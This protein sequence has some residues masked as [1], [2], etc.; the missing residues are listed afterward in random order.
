VP[1]VLSLVLAVCLGWSAVVVAASPPSETLFPSNTKGWV[2]FPNVDLLRSDFKLTQ[3][4]K[5][6]EDPAMQP[7]MEDLGEQLEEKLN[8]AGVK[9]GLKLADLDGV[10]GGEVAT[11]M[12]KP[13]PKDKNSHALAFVVDITGKAKAAHELLEKIDKNLIAKGAKK[14]SKKVGTTTVISYLLPK[15]A[16]EKAPVTAY[17]AIEGNTLIAADNESVVLGILTRLEGKAADSLGATPA[18]K[19]VAAKVHGKK[20]ALD[21]HIRWFVEPLGYA[22]AARAANGGKVKRG[23]DKIRIL[24]EQGFTCI[25]GIG[26]RLDFHHGDHE[27]LHQSFAYAPADPRAKKPL[28][29]V[30]AAN[31]LDFPNSP[32]LE[33]QDWVPNHVSSYLSFNWD[34]QKAFEHFGSIFDAFADDPGTWDEVIGGLETDPSGPEIN[35]KDELIK[36]LG[37]RVTA[38]VDYRLPIDP[39]CE[40]VLVAIELNGKIDGVEKKVQDAIRKLMK[41]E[42]DAR[43][44]KIEGHD[45]WEVSERTEEAEIPELNIDS[46]EFVA[47][48]GKAV[49]EKDGEAVAVAAPAVKEKKINWAITVAKGHVFIGTHVA[50]IADVLRIRRRRNSSRTPRTWRAFARRWS[51]WV[52]TTTASASSLVPM[53]PAIPPTSCSRKGLCPRPKRCWVARSTRPSHRRRRVRFASRRSTAR[54]FPPGRRW[55]ATS[56]PPARSCSRRTTAG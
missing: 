40:R 54:S 17:Y 36:R 19:Q 45:G 12:I 32:E 42:A 41:V 43:A 25:Q 37:Q 23:L 5:L 27:L 53:R 35:V 2:S 16:E 11:G 20:D 26:G 34:I 44:I 52:P 21:T 13:D 56:A 1:R 10:Y 24:R 30:K 47:L 28:K 33:V 18:Y 55:P 4:G 29:Y 7:F 48:E 15:K 50:L 38:I 22:E 8:E 46:P 51:N 49:E 39:T 6:V 3:L 9:L 14:A 31:I